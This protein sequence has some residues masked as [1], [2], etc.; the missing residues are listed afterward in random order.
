MPA[1][2]AGPVF[3]EARGEE[4]L[5]LVVVLLQNRIEF[6]IVA[7]G[8]AVGH[9]HE[10]GAHGI[11]DIVQNLLAAQNWIGQIALVRPEPV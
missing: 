11:G 1:Q 5:Q 10:N 8:T 9:A 4:G 3:I 2:Q 6:V 7:A